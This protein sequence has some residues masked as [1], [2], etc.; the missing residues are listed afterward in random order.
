VTVGGG[1]ATL[2]KSGDLLFEFLP[3]G[4]VLVVA[5]AILR[6][7]HRLGGYAHKHRNRVKFLLRSL[8]FSAWR[9]PV[10]NGPA[11]VPRAGGRAPPE[12]RGEGGAPPP[13]D[14][15]HP[16]TEA[17]PDWERPAPPSSSEVFRRAASAEVRGPGIVPA[18]RPALPLL[19]ADLGRWQATNVR[20]Q[21][22]D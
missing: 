6:V 14:R 8:G 10:G 21:K 2:C 5:E 12:V 9:A 7:F 1:T 15:E 18:V 3:A 20:R 4:D 19:T 17:A 11:P 22:Q 13:S 16:R